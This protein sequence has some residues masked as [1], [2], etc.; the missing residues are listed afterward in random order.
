MKILRYL[1]II[2]IHIGICHC[3]LLDRY[4]LSSY[5][6][7]YSSINARARTSTGQTISISSYDALSMQHHAN[8]YDNMP[9]SWVM[10][11][12]QPSVSYIPRYSVYSPKPIHG[13]S[14]YL[15][16]GS[17]TRLASSTSLDIKTN[18]PP[19]YLKIMRLVLGLY[20]LLVL[21]KS[22]A[23]L[24]RKYSIAFPSALGGMIA[25]FTTLSVVNVVD[26]KLADALLTEYLPALSFLR[27]WLALFF[28]PPLV[29]IPLKASLLSSNAYQ[30]LI[31]MVV[32]FVMSLLSSAVVAKSFMKSEPT[33]SNRTSEVEPIS[34]NKVD[35]PAKSPSS[36]PSVLP[37]PTMALV[38]SLVSFLYTG[39]PIL[40]KMRISS[41]AFI[42]EFVITLSRYQSSSRKPV[43][44]SIIQAKS[45]CLLP[46]HNRFLSRRESMD[47]TCS[48]E[49]RS[50][51]A[52]HRDAFHRLTIHPQLY[53]QPTLPQHVE[54][55]LWSRIR[56]R[57]S[58]LIDARTS[59]PELRHSTFPISRPPHLQLTAGILDILIFCCLRAS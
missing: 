20:S 48:E 14:T 19:F 55:L 33:A 42:Y 6:S 54:H 17:S 59:H 51:S 57:R 2:M 36:P 50:S 31:V 26:N 39:Q 8:N 34:M 35:S 15:S 37:N 41:R 53:C 22:F 49:N 3:F 16:S 10:M 27:A 12:I 24:F 44:R 23:Q 56:C 43:I 47:L 13:Y 28:I 52:H 7:P 18:E 11:G 38:L 46:I 29:V 32:G 4:K 40:L 30:L 21:D 1:L 9:S 25:I 58:H 45:S 5:K